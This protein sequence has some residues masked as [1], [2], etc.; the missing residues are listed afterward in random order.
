MSHTYS[1]FLASASFF[2]CSSKMY[3]VR[4]KSIFTVPHLFD[5][6]K[7]FFLAFDEG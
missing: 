3:L 1:C 4:E 6:E 2:Y 7:E 5:V